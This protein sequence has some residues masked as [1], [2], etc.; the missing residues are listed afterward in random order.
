MVALGLG[1]LV[2]MSAP[3]FWVALGYTNSH[4]LAAL[5]I[6]MATYCVLGSIK[7]LTFDGRH[8]GL[9][10][11]SAIVLA[12]ARFEGAVLFLVIISPLMLSL[13]GYLQP[14][15]YRVLWVAYIGSAG[16]L[17]WVLLS[18]QQ[19]PINPFLLFGL[20]ASAPPL[21]L[22]ATRLGGPRSERILVLG[23][24]FSLLATTVLVLFAEYGLSGARA[25][26]F[27][28]FRN[29]L[30]GVSGWGAVISATLIATVWVFFPAKSRIYRTSVRMWW[31]GILV[32]I[33]LKLLDSP[34]GNEGFNNTLSRTF[35]HWLA[36]LFVLW[37]IG[38]YESLHARRPAKRL[39]QSFSRRRRAD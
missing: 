32:T 24:W 36:P 7:A 20:L 31:W 22:L 33:I 8:V 19:L 27:A 14:Y 5:A 39:V 15:R 1:L 21:V 29:L 13:A 28:Q 18:A 3:I 2:V 11:V 38:L 30:L 9:L 25:I 10:S 6:A 26:A 16:L 35:L 4:V 23:G 12:T 17:F 34:P 37:I